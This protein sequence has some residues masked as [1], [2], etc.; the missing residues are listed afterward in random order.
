[1]KTCTKCKQS[2]QLTNFSK[3]KNSKDGLQNWCRQCRSID[4]LIHCS[5]YK[6]KQ[7]AS[8]AAHYLANKENILAKNQEYYL[9]N[10][11]KEAIRK[12]HYYALNRIAIDAQRKAY[13]EKNKEKCRI[14]QAGYLKKYY[15][16]N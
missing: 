5:K 11:E 3:N 12:A 2:K 9:A 15:H 6:V 7:A 8:N 1:M 10:K 4:H 13:K 16:A 14:R